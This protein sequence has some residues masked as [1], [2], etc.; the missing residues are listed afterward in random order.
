MSNGDA[1][2]IDIVPPVTKS[3]CTRWSGTLGLKLPSVDV[4]ARVGLVADGIAVTQ[5]NVTGGVWNATAER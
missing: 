3:N 1:V 4:N 2:P 5:R